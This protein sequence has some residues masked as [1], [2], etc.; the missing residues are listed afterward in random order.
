[1]SVR[2][3]YV[4]DSEQFFIFRDGTPVKPADMRKILKKAL[5]LEKIDTSLYRI[6][7]LRAGKST[8]L[9]RLGVLVETIRKVGR[10]RSNAVFAYFKE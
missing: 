1:M 9:L 3:D 4:T 10:W 6:H 7:S 2:G 8:E 5:E